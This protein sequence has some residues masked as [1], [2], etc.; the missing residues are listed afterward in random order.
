MGA[1]VKARR[2]IGR[3]IV[4]FGL[5][6][7]GYGGWYGIALHSLTSR[8][9]AFNDRYAPVRKPN[10]QIIENHQLKAVVDFKTVSKWAAAF[11]AAEPHLQN[12]ISRIRAGEGMAFWLPD[13]K[14]SEADRF[15]AQLRRDAELVKAARQA[16]AALDN[17]YGSITRSVTEVNAEHERATGALAPQSDIDDFE[18]ES[19]A[20]V[21]ALA[22]VRERQSE[23]RFE[24][25]HNRLSEVTE[26]F[27]R[28]ILN[29]FSDLLHNQA[30]QLQHRKSTLEQ[31]ES[32]L[33]QL[34][35]SAL[36]A[37][38]E[39]QKLL[40]GLEHISTAL[41][42]AVNFSYERTKDLRQFMNDAE[43]PIS[44]DAGVVLTGFV[45]RGGS[46]AGPVTPISMV[47]DLDPRA[48]ILLQTLKTLCDAIER[49]HSEV[50]GLSD[51]AAG[52]LP[53]L[54]S[55]LNTGGRSGLMTLANE[56]PQAAAYF[57]ERRGLFDPALA[58]MDRIRP[59][60]D[61]L[62][63]R[64]SGLRLAQA[65]AILQRGIAGASSIVDGAEQPF[66]DGNAV[67]ESTGSSLRQVQ[68]ADAQYVQLLASLRSSIAPPVPA[69]EG[70]EKSPE[71][72]P[73][74]ETAGIRAVDFKNF[75]YS[76]KCGESTVREGKAAAGPR[77]F[78]VESV[79]FGDISNDGVEEATIVFGCGTGGKAFHTEVLVYS[80]ADGS[81]R[82]IGKVGGGDRAFGG[83]R[84]VSIEN[85]R[86]IVDRNRATE[87]AAMCCADYAETSKFKIEDGKLL[88][89]GEPVRRR[90]TESGT[91]PRP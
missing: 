61:A 2:R 6:I 74:S 65:R 8:I 21:R 30:G 82:L 48:K 72:A 44:G 79:S 11:D 60:L 68:N 53:P 73:P 29:G 33:R 83:I 13:R 23:V 81:P 69:E 50:N 42:P 80:M 12:E 4:I 19:A 86:L 41:L 47:S 90:L 26:E 88:R 3:Y 1:Q 7:A 10:L 56:A 40:S 54:R 31:A 66:R 17:T 39:N 63:A 27:R 32:A 67:I 58:E 20:M 76:S 77:E 14:R 75:T 89:E 52:I 62:S 85:G 22:I 59:V 78:D 36:G 38:T 91:V 35:I 15:D 46:P 64:V 25:T 18:R 57:E 37:A 28:A 9:Q 45:S 55:F 84:S 51:M 71:A 16:L 49:S 5:L 24:Q 70:S 34:K 43:Q 87:N